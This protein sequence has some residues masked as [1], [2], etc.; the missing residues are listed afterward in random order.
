[1]VVHILKSTAVL[2][3][4]MVFYKLVLEREKMH[5]FKRF[6]LLF[7]V[8]VA[9][10]IPFLSFITYQKSPVLVTEF[11]TSLSTANTDVKASDLN[12]LSLLPV[13]IWSIYIL[14]LVLFAIKF[15][16][17]LLML[18]RRVRSNPKIES[19]QDIIVLMSIDVSPHSFLNYIFLNKKEY[20]AS[21]IPKEVLVHERAHVRQN[22][23]W[24]ILFIEFIQILLWFHPLV[25]FLKESIKLNHEFLA[26]KTV[27]RQGINPKKYQKTLL[28]FSSK[29]FHNSLVHPVNFSF[30]KKR[31]VVMKKNRTK[32]DA[33]LRMLLVLPLTIF[34]SYSFSSQEIVYSSLAPQETATS[35][36]V[37]EYNELVSYYESLDTGYIIIRLQD[38]KRMS[39]IYEV[40]T[41]EQ[42]Q[43]AKDF[44]NNLLPPPPP[45]APIGLDTTIPP[46]PPSSSVD[47]KPF[48]PTNPIEVE[49]IP[50]TPPSPKDHLRELEE[51][52]ARYFHNGRELKLEA[53]LEVLGTTGLSVRVIQFVDLPPTVI[54]ETEQ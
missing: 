18:V 11:S 48:D 15:G 43:Q 52:G 1:M 7:S 41:P 40:M 4:L 37:E 51:E 34:L 14:G 21:K 38:I 28:S 2:L 22:H 9:I 30:I 33:R 54:L 47:S 13:L 27:L 50:R 5:E 29:K 3:V 46:P 17:N 12:Y 10:S 24:D 31:I 25:Y 20:L 42:K 19:K 49:E 16:K 35:E 44:P 45:P 6:Y 53:A 32:T 26:D 8:I 39:H 36:M 23:S